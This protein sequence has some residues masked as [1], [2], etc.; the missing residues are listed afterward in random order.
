[1]DIFIPWWRD[2]NL[3]WQGLI[4]M[5]PNAFMP[6]HMLSINQK[7]SFCSCVQWRFSFGQTIATSSRSVCWP[8]KLELFASLRQFCAFKISTKQSLP[9]SQMILQFFC[10]LLNFTLFSRAQAFLFYKWESI[11]VGCS[12]G[13][14]LY[15]FAPFFWTIQL[16]SSN[17]WR[18]S[19]FDTH[20]SKSGQDAR[21]K[22][23]MMQYRDIMEPDTAYVSVRSSQP[24]K[25]IQGSYCLMY[26]RQRWGSSWSSVWGVCVSRFLRRLL[27]VERFSVLGTF[28]STL[29]PDAPRWA[30][31]R[32]DEPR[33]PLQFWFKMFTVPRRHQCAASLS[34]RILKSD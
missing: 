1:M 2:V 17:P 22:L 5:H 8:V 27:V 28:A 6:S 29:V 26:F 21:G 4:R 16:S 12:F 7:H 30:W 18:P 34:P 25:E 19:H 14:N 32:K 33:W 3:V 24:R 31:E 15:Q 20:M 13:P 23:R 9:F 11:F 10:R